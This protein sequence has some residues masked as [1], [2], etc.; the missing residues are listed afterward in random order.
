MSRARRYQRKMARLGA[1]R[2]L[3]EPVP[4]WDTVLSDR[5]VDE[6]YRYLREVHGYTHEAAVREIMQRTGMSGS[7]IDVAVANVQDQIQAR[8]QMRRGEAWDPQLLRGY[9][10]RVR[11][12]LV[13]LGMK[14]ADASR[15]VRWFRDEVENRW[16][17][18]GISA[19]NAAERL[20][21]R[22]RR[23]ERSGS[24]YAVSNGDRVVAHASSRASAHRASRRMGNVG[25]SVSN[26]ARRRTFMEARSEILAFL[27]GERW[28]VKSDL[29]YPHAISPDGRVHLYF[30]PQ[31]VYLGMAGA[32]MGNTRS[33]WVDIRDI[34]G[35]SFMR[36]VEAD[37]RR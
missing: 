10:K 25:S 12:H 18:Q 9:S 31:A 5:P 4:S 36:A 19:A 26:R 29:K 34:D 3:R 13:E 21:D 27:R 24:R 1:R 20:M 17:K 2:G 30:K 35:P 8:L 23:W 32:G 7:R 14:S 11:E 6:Q 37:A 33:M 15:R 28:T 16:Y 22:H